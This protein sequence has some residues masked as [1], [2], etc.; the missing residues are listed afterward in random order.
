MDDFYFFKCQIVLKTNVYILIIIFY[1]SQ[2]RD[3]LYLTVVSNNACHFSTLR[4]FQVRQKV[5]KTLH[6]SFTYPPEELK[7][8]DKIYSASFKTKDHGPTMKMQAVTFKSAAEL[9]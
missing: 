1:T 4:E 9:A 6:Q 7:R 3:F 8:A 2:L 5:M